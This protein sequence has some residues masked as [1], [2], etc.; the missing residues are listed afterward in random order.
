MIKKSHPN[1]TLFTK[2]EILKAIV[3]IGYFKLDDNIL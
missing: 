2:E 1:Q 3:K